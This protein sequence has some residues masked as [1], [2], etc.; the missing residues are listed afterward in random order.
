MKDITRRLRLI[1]T[2]RDLTQRDTAIKADMP[3]MRYWEIENGY[4]TP[5]DAEVSRL[6]RALKVDRTAIVPTPESEIA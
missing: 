5:T 6:A 2:E 1:R 4:R 3:T